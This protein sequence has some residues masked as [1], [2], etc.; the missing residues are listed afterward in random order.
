MTRR[1]GFAIGDKLVYVELTR[2]SRLWLPLLYAGLFVGI[3]LLK[4]RHP[5]QCVI[6][7]SSLANS[8]A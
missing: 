1:V 2:R 3:V 6:H 5:R 7:L 8:E 4:L